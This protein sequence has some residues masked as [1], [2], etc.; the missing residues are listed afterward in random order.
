M[1]D[2]LL[3]LALLYADGRREIR[4][5]T[6]LQKLAFLA[7]EEYGAEDLHEF[8]PDK[9]G[10]FSPSLAGAVEALKQRG[11]LKEREKRVPGGNE[12][13]IYSLT[14][15]GVRV[16]KR[17]LH[18]RDEDVESTLESAERVKAEWG[19]SSLDR[20]LQHVYQSY[21]HYTSE[22]RLD[23]AETV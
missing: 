23:L 21:P 18:D 19:D 20:L 16:V 14:D 13:L 10:P 15:K 6:R 17:L 4:G 1:T 9:Y 11:L 8:E 2:V 22:S 5:A 12:M 3:P 7:Q